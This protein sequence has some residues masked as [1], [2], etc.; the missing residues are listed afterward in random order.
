MKKILFP[1]LCAVLFVTSASAQVRVV[2]SSDAKTGID[3]SGLRA[4]SGAAETT[5]ARTLENNLRLSGWFAP[6]RGSAELR[7]IGTVNL[8]GSNLKVIAQVYRG[9]DQ[10][11]LFSKNYSAKTPRA[12]E[13]AHRVADDIVEALTGR[14]G[15]ASSRIT[16]VG[17]R[18]GHKELY[19]CDADG[20]ALRQVTQDRNIVVGP[21]WGPRGDRIV[22]TAY[23]RGFPDVYSVNLQ[24]GRRQQL[25]SYAGVNT[26]A[27][28]S[29]N[30]RELALVLSKDGNPDLYIKS[31]SSGKL[32]RL[33]HTPRATEAS[34]SW[35]PDGRH[36]VYVSDSSGSPQLY[37]IAR[38]GGAPKRISSR[39][40]ENVAPDWGPN[41]LI[42][43]ASRS[44]GRYAVSLINPATGQTRYL[45][46]DYA[47]YEDPSWAPDGRHLVCTRTERYRSSLY[48]LDTV[49]DPPVALLEGHGDWYSPAWSPE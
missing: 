45:N 43:C 41:G 3:F 22:Y 7:L 42:A 25:A 4:G 37:V 1:V 33:T 18:S 49:N 28:I 36:L 27:A 5:F 6:V 23:L 21:E 2:K 34:A 30:G 32:R 46:T 20:G 19:V 14:K 15:M 44:G 13:L 16:V 40:T 29:P 26:G 12:R 31:L 24:S 39:G 48:L 35:S 11:R 38:E 10:A 8:S 47:D 9:A 17:T